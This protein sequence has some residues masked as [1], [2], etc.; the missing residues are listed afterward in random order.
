MKIL[1]YI[2]LL[3]SSVLGIA[4]KKITTFQH[5]FLGF[6]MNGGLYMNTTPDSC[7]AVCGQHASSGAGGC[8]I[9]VYKRDKCGIIKFYKTYGGTENEGGSCLQPTSD[10]GMIVSG[11][12]TSF[13]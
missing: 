11:F 12:G 2:I 8:D 7:F 5:T 10:G 9:Y 1:L 6:G 4:Q 13:P 3:F